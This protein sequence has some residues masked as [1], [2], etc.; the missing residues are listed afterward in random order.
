MIS[1]RS[2]EK[3]S[4]NDLKRLLRIANEDRRDFFARHPKWKKLYSKRIL[5]ITLCQGAAQHF[6][7]NKNGVKDFD[8]WTFYAECPGQPFPYRRMGHRDFGKSK[9]GVHPLD[10]GKFEGRCVDLLGRSIKS[11]PEADPVKAV[12]NYL[13]NGNTKSAL[14]IAK[15]AIVLLWPSDSLGEIIWPI[16]T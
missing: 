6:F 3:I 4:R 5:C 1:E 8:V 2:Y 13:K 12:H 11:P 14:E 9:F 7:D 10:I 15:K 16:E